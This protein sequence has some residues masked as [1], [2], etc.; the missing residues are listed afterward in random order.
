MIV[1]ITITV[2]IFWLRILKKLE[3][4]GKLNDN[5]SVLGC[6]FLCGLLSIPVVHLLHEFSA[7]SYAHIINLSLFTYSVLFVG[8]FEETAKFLVFYVVARSSS[9]IKEPKDGLLQAASV[10][11]AFAV[12]ENV[13][14]AGFY[15]L[16]NLLLRSVTG[17]M[18]HMAF[19]VIWGYAGGLYLC[20]RRTGK[21]EYSFSMVSGAVASAA[22]FHGF[23]NYFI[24]LDLS[25]ISYLILVLSVGITVFIL[26]Y[27]RKR[28]PYRPL[29]FT[30]SKAALD[31][32]GDAL[33]LNPG[34][35]LLN[36]RAGFHSI[37]AGSY[38]EALGY[39]KKASSV[40]HKELSTRVY[41]ILLE[42][43]LNLLEEYFAFRELDK[44]CSKVSVYNLI[45]LKEQAAELFEG[46][47][48]R[49]NLTAMLDD[50]IDSIRFAQRVKNRIA[51]FDRAAG[52]LGSSS[53]R[54]FLIAG[55]DNLPMAYRHPGYYP[56]DEE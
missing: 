3:S 17:T 52:D 5:R 44:V 54:G 28:S 53:N 29:S 1:L 35:F 33:C 38:T 47:D 27:L 48:G 16:E 55:K 6:M 24:Y 40:N 32:I 51:E 7:F 4:H 25:L 18:G 23:F 39:L 49:E 12:T 30:E 26:R 11:L 13:K 15:G 31:D 46:C 34:S 37:K 2:S 50:M 43:H 10:A 19:A 14:Y 56:A 21:N 42:Y 41:V 36:K 22:V 45:R 20:S 8:L 9:F